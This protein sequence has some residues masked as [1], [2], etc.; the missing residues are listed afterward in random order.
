MYI[1]AETLAAGGVESLAMI[2]SF[3]KIAENLRKDKNMPRGMADVI[4][5]LE[6]DALVMSGKFISEIEAWEKAMAKA[7]IDFS[8]RFVDIEETSVFWKNRH[9]KMLEA[10]EPTLRAIQSRLGAFMDDLIAIARCAGKEEILALSSK[11]A[12]ALKAKLRADTAVDN[13]SIKDILETLRR[14]A[15]EFRGVL[16][17]KK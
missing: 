5:Q 10:F 12:A 9:D 6:T 16:G 3:I 15:E 2:N 7:H 17:T 8:S 11:E 13:H 1:P 4:S 14:Q